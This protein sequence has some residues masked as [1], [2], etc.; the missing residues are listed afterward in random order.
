MKRQ[1]ELFLNF[2]FLRV[3]FYHHSSEREPIHSPVVGSST[4]TD[5]THVCDLASVVSIGTSILVFEVVCQRI[6]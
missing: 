5:T 4:C 2:S 3:L 1:K 6:I